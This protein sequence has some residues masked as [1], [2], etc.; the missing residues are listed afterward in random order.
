MGNIRTTNSVTSENIL[1]SFDQQKWTVML[2]WYFV[3]FY[4]Y[5][6]KE[7][8]KVNNYNHFVKKRV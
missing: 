4:I 8:R 7:I 5:S 3:K 6:G 2:K 1:S